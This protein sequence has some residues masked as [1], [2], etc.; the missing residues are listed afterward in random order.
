MKPT[1]RDVEWVICAKFKIKPEVLKMPVRRGRPLGTR[2]TYRPR[3]IAYFLARESTGYSYPRIGLYFS[4]DHTT[5][6]EGVRRI[7]GLIQ[8]NPKVAAYVAECMAA[9][10]CMASREAAIRADAAKG[11]SPNAVT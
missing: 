5:I 6:L 3:Q 7:R 1:L 11:F 10:P 2:A 8:T 9:L 4:R